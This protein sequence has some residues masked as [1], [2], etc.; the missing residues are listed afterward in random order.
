MFIR[1][2][3]RGRY[4][5]AAA[6]TGLF[7]AAYRFRDEKTLLEEQQVELADLLLT[8]QSTVETLDLEPPCLDFHPKVLYWYKPDAFDAL[9]QTQA[10]ADFLGRQGFIVDVEKQSNPG[11]IVGEDAVQIAVANCNWRERLGYI[12]RYKVARVR[13]V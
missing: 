11:F 13:L 3:T 4:G 10:L 12:L 8:Y 5:E 2:T 1:F 7:E 9:A 6:P